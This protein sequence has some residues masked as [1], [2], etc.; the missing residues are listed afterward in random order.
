M[1]VMTPIPFTRHMAT[2]LGKKYV[3]YGEVGQSNEALFRYISTAN[4]ELTNSLMVVL[5]TILQRKELVD[6]NNIVYTGYPWDESAKPYRKKQT[7]KYYVDI[8]NEPQANAEFWRQHND[9]RLACLQRGN[10]L[11]SLWD[12]WDGYLDSTTI[13]TIYD[14]MSVIDPSHFRNFS[15]D[16]DCFVE[17]S[18]RDYCVKNSMLMEDGHGDENSHNHFSQ[19]LIGGK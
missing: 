4:M 11:I 12:R 18:F 19:L 10:R 2:A 13:N 8:Y 6:T 16:S 17:T 3:Q 14:N 7:E 9:I 5:F 1:L 15:V